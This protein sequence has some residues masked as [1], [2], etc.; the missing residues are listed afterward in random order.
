[1][2]HY[3]FTKRTMFDIWVIEDIESRK[4]ERLNIVVEL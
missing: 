4:F 1:M 3:L 2:V